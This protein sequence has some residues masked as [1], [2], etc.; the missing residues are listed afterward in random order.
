MHATWV[1]N[2]NSAKTHCSLDVDPGLDK[3]YVETN[4][5]Y[6]SKYVPF[7]M[8]VLEE[9]IMCNFVN[10]LANMYSVDHVLYCVC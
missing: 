4:D 3:I 2:W 7:M 1:V 8:S 5:I 10:H 9:V 6:I